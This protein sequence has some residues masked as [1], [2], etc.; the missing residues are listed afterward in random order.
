MVNSIYRAV[1]TPGRPR[2]HDTGVPAGVGVPQ[3]QGLMLITGPLGIRWQGFRPRLENSAITLANPPARSRIHFWID[4]RIG[5]AGRPDWIFVKAHMHGFE[6]LSS[7]L[8]TGAMPA[9]HRI[10]QDEFN[11]GTSWCLHYV[12]AREMYNIA[13]AAETGRTGS[14]SE[15]RDYEIRRPNCT[16]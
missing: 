3:E 13:A 6:E 7:G 1:D 4:S 14:P 8:L 15:W 12:S 16:K 5:V 11:D 9:M 10:L 2:G